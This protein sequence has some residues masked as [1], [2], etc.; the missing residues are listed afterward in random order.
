MYAKSIAPVSSARQ[1]VAPVVADE[2]FDELP[3]ECRTALKR[4]SAQLLEIQESERRRIATDLHDG[5]GQSLTMIKHALDESALLLE[6]NESEEALKSLQHV[7]QR[8]RNALDELH[9]IAL[10]LRPAMLDDLGILATLSWFFR[11]FEADCHDVKVEKQF[12]VKESNIPASLK[13]VIFRIIQEATNN[14]VKHAHASRMRVVLRST[15]NLLHL[16]VEDNGDGFDT[17]SDGKIRP[18]GKG[19]GLLTM[20]ERA[21]HC[22]GRYTLESA[23]GQGTCIKVTWPLDRVADEP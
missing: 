10:D 16:L 11:E 1:S 19:L 7:R 15:D 8:V 12:E 22:G 3:G 2:P 5:L 23:M 20:A 18:L 17:F 6:K 9:A 13:I 4:M 14:I 21:E